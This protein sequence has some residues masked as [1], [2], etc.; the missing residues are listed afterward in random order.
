M[1]YQVEMKKSEREELK[2][3]ALAANKA[4]GGLPWQVTMA[5][6]DGVTHYH[7]R[8]HCEPAIAVVKDEYWE[9]DYEPP[10]DDYGY[11]QPDERMDCDP[12]RVD[13]ARHIAAANPDT[14]LE[15]IQQR[16]ELLAAL[17]DAREMVSDWGAYATAYM[18]EKH[19]LA[20][21][22]E[23]LDAAISKVEEQS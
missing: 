8:G 2:Q 4:Y 7:I 16:D 14:I 20:G 6:H 13:I 21:D 15:L 9:D 22:L 17:K 23:R 10:V 3:K 11:N 1:Q 12:V 18:Q 5:R 19:D